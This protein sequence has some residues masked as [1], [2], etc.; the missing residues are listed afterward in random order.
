MTRYFLPIVAVAMIVSTA[1]AELMLIE[2]DVVRAKDGTWTYSVQSDN[3]RF[4]ND[5]ALAT[6]L[7]DL[8][9]PKDSVYLKIRSATDVP[10]E[11]IV[12]ILEMTKA[13]RQGIRVK[14]IMLDTD[15]F[16]ARR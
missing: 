5:A 10:I 12:R 1:R 3:L 7:R 4:G 13:N 16:N 9:N 15:T 11:Q 8:R 14:S 2:L 6:Y